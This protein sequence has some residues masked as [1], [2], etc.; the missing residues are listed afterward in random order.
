MTDRRKGRGHTNARRL[1]AWPFGTATQVAELCG[2]INARTVQKL[3]AKHV[4]PTPERPGWYHLPRC[5]AAYCPYVQEIHG[6]AAD[7]GEDIR[8]AKL[9]YWTAR[10]DLE[11]LEAEAKA[12]TLIP[13]AHAELIL[14][15]AIAALRVECD[16][17]AGRLAP[18]LAVESNAAVIRRRLLD[19]YR[20]ACARAAAKVAELTPTASPRET[21]RNETAEPEADGTRS[22]SQTRR[23]TAEEH[24][25]GS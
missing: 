8:S 17:N 14:T 23:A 7:D 9:R 1:P 21:R 19:E 22:G 11:E 2:G 3:V 25:T 10:A 5:V 24:Q 12:G 20:G 15:E 18:G 6:S 13:Y 4:L 16:A